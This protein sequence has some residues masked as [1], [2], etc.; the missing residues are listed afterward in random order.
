MRTFILAEKDEYSD[1][2]EE[3]GGRRTQKNSVPWPT[4]LYRGVF[5]FGTLM[6]HHQGQVAPRNTT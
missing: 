2:N 6:G 3:M 4:F 1:R 5:I